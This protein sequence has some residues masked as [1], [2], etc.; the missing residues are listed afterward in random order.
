MK[1]LNFFIFSMLSF[2]ALIS[3]SDLSE[4]TINS[5]EELVYL[6]YEPKGIPE[7]INLPDGNFI[8]MDIDSTFFLKISHS[9]KNK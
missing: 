6:A 8:Y 1:K 5:E 3:C 4:E 7:K 2:T 9:Q